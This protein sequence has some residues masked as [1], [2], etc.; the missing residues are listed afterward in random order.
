MLLNVIYSWLAVFLLRTMH[1]YCTSTF[2]VLLV[3]LCDEYE[4]LSER[5]GGKGINNRKIPTIWENIEKVEIFT[6]C[7]VTFDLNLTENMTYYLKV[8]SNGREGKEGWWVQWIHQNSK[9]TAASKWVWIMFV[10]YSWWEKKKCNNN[11]TAF[12]KINNIH[13]HTFNN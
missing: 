3:N 10:D 11:N 4:G 12:K 2:S 1:M 9:G 7:P 13:E 5:L 8:C 6:S